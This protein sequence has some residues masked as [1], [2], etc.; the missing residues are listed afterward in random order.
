[1]T[2]TKKQ[3]SL[4]YGRFYSPSKYHYSINGWTD[5]SSYSETEIEEMMYEINIEFRNFTLRPKSLN[6]LQFNI[7]NI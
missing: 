2:D 7:T 4:A 6:H 5:I 1:M 3:I